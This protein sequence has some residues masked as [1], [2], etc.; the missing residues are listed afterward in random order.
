MSIDKMPFDKMLFDKMS[1]GKMSFDKMSLDKMLF[2]EKSVC[3][4]SAKTEKLELDNNGQK[5]EK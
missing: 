1:F 2:Y 4:T 5:S 3:H